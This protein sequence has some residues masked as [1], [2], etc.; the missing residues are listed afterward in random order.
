MIRPGVPTTMWTPRRRALQLDAVPLA[1]VDREHVHALEVGGVLLE[2][3]ADLER[4]LAGR[5]Q[6]QGLRLLLRQVEPGQDRQRER[7]GLARARL[8]EPDDVAAAEQGGD[9]G[10]LDGRGGLVAD[11]LHGLEDPGVEP[12]VGEGDLVLGPVRIVVH[13]STVEPSAVAAR[14]LDLPGVPVGFTRL[15][16]TTGSHFGLW[17]SLVA[18]L[19]G[20]QGVAGSNPVSP[21]EET[22]GQRPFPRSAET[23]SSLSS[24]G[25]STGCSN[26]TPTSPSERCGK[27]IDCR[28]RCAIRDVTVDVARDRHRLMAEEIGHNFER[29]PTLDHHRRVGV[30]ERVEADVRQF[31]L[32]RCTCSALSAL[33]GLNVVRCCEDVASVRPHIGGFYALSGLALPVLPEHLPHRS[34]QRHSHAAISSITVLDMEDG[35]WRPR[36][37]LLARYASVDHII[38]LRE[39]IKRSD[40]AVTINAPWTLMRGALEPAGVVF[41]YSPAR[42]GPRAGLAPYAFYITTTGSVASWSKSSASS[43]RK[44]RTGKDRAKEIEK[45]ADSLAGSTSPRSSPNSI[46]ATQ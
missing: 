27:A 28:T 46:L 37:E 10:G 12:Q 6:D 25:C 29:H 13:G 24:A 18:H 11:V 34:R 16:S 21:T 20:G 19:T 7:R 35:R 43:P 31:G 1:A 3:L 5:R 14:F 26:G 32:D 15:T 4:Q 30:P 22:A 2:R 45:L 9:G 41:G 40:A 36:E 38:Q 44:R 39:L 23:V 8:R 17:R 42:P 33:R